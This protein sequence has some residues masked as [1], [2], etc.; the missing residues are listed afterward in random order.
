MHDTGHTEQ[1]FAVDQWCLSVEASLPVGSLEPW[2][3]VNGE[4]FP[5]TVRVSASKN[6]GED[7]I[8]CLVDHERTVR[9]T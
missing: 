2:E 5:A 3:G 8:V 4:M 6:P 1:L 9:S 7:T